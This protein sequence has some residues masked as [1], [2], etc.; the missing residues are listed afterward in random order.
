MLRATVA[1]LRGRLLAAVDPEDVQR[2]RAVVEELRGE[3]SS[4]SRLAELA[5]RAAAVGGA[6]ATGTD[7]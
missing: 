5:E 3:I 6:G 1:T 4:F 2:A 7:F